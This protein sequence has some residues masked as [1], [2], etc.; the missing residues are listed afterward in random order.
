MKRRAPASLLA[1]GGGLHGWRFV[2]FDPAIEHP[3]SVVPSNDEAGLIADAAR[4]NVAVNNTAG[5]EGGEMASA[6]AFAGAAVRS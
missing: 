2:G 4:T 1:R 6:P 3:E 5:G